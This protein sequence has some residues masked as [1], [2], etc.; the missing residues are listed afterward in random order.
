MALRTPCLVAFWLATIPATLPVMVAEG[1]E[2]RL[3]PAGPADCEALSDRFAR[4]PRAR[5]EPARSLA[6]E[7]DRLCRSG[8]IQAGVLKLRRAIRAAQEPVLH[9]PRGSSLA[10]RQDAP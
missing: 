9:V 10:V 3:L 4:Q 5:Q 1:P 7:G 8:N 6:R 2:L